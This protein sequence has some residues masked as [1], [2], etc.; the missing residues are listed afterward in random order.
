M[1]L[2]LHNL[3]REPVSIT[4]MK[5]R[6]HYTNKDLSLMFEVSEFTISNMFVTWIN[7]M[8]CQWKEL[9]LWPIKDLVAFFCPLDFNKQFPNCR[10]IIDGT[11]VP[12][13]TPN[14][15]NAQQKQ[16]IAN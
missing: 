6:K 5:L 13:K 11:E 2:V 1:R 15:T 4:M 16:N 10:I 14:N 3:H 9:D 7:F 12:I 8:Y